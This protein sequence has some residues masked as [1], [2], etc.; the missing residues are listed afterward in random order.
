MSLCAET[1][2]RAMW[3]PP[4]AA[5][6]I[7]RMAGGMP[8]RHAPTGASQRPKRHL[9]TESNGHLPEEAARRPKQPP[10]RA[11][12][13]VPRIWSAA[14]CASMASFRTVFRM[15]QQQDRPR[16]SH[17]A[18]SPSPASSARATCYYFN[19]FCRICLHHPLCVQHFLEP[20]FPY[21]SYLQRKNL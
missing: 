18:A 20:L 13:A 10:A 15:P 2:L 4:R 8:K 21:H 19:D 17:A 9:T 16:A 14:L 7:R 12:A 11:I 1:T 3:N 5:D 6:G